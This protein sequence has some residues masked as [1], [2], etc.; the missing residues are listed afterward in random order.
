[1][2]RLSR[3][4]T[5]QS[6]AA[7]VAVAQELRTQIKQNGSQF[8]DP[9]DAKAV[10][11]L[12][13]LSVG[14]YETFKRKGA[15]FTGTLKSIF[16]DGL[17]KAGVSMEDHEF[18]SAFTEAQ[19]EAGHMTAAALGNPVGYAMEAYKDKSIGNNRD[20]NAVFHASTEGMGYTDT[21]AMEAFDERELD[22]HGDISIVFNVSAARQDEFGEAF[23]PT[24][25]VS[26]DQ[27]G[28][29]ISV[30]RVMIMNEFRHSL[31]GVR[32]DF[33][34]KNLLDAITEPTILAT[35][36][37]LLVPVYVSSGDN[38]NTGMFATGISA[39]TKT[40]ED[41]TQV[42][43]AP[44]KVG[45][46]LDLLGL[47]QR[48]DVATQGQFDHM[49]S[50]D[51]RIVLDK[52][53]FSITGATG[54]ETGPAAKTNFFAFDTSRLPRNQFTKTVEGNN[55][56][57]QLTFDT[58]DIPLYA[59]LTDIAGVAAATDGSGSH[60]LRYLENGGRES[61]VVRLK[62]AITGR[63]NHETGNVEVNAGSLTIDSVW[64]VNDGVWTA[65]TGSDLTNLRAEFATMSMVGYDLKVYRTNLNLRTRGLQTNTME[66]VER[67]TIPLLSPIHAPAPTTSNRDAAELQTL[68]HAARIRNSNNAVTQLQAYAS[69]LSA[70][71]VSQDRRVPQPAIEGIG[72]LLVRAFYESIELDVSAAINSIKSSDRVADVN[73][74][75]VNMIREVSARMY[76]LSGYQAALDMLTGT[77]GLKPQLLI[78][79]D[80]EIAKHLIVDGDTRLGGTNFEARVVTSHDRR[81]YG[82]MYITFTR[83]D[84]TTP[85]PL[86]FGNMLWM[87]ELAGTVQLTRNNST[88]KETMVQ[89]RARHVNHLPILVEVDVTNLK[90]AVASKVA[91]DFSEV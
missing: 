27:A 87:P 90:A 63:A 66:H 68:I 57:S 47:G 13:S 75:F 36:S 64:D 32:A 54:N 38:A 5:G 91:I 59:T 37:T 71:R 50:L 10:L 21:V 69:M 11:S 40:L 62:I 55:R 79:T 48:T 26:P 35:E 33:D 22:K 28:L 84:Q 44:L 20:V 30:R 34:R 76:R 12:E 41:G 74:V 1:M 31:T 18:E 65:V 78:G 49:D 67:Y 58:V 60:A 23:Y 15:E 25:V 70:Y 61:W 45:V 77:P 16:R 86:S 89:P 17:T 24:F 4:G 42:T 46:S 3:K 88:I 7:L 51:S 72:R 80:T 19:W 6:G 29:D 85:D 82:K 73:A 9:Q 83:P 52:V 39:Y 14:E 56:E 81:V 8:I 2:S 43:T 53:Y